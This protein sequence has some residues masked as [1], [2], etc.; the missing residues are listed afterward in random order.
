MF[1]EIL[2]ASQQHSINRSD[3]KLKKKISFFGC[4]RLVI[5]LSNSALLIWLDG[6]PVCLRYLPVYL[7]PH[8]P[9]PGSSTRLGRPT[10]IVSLS[11]SR[12]T[13]LT[14][15][16]TLDFRCVYVTLSHPDLKNPCG[17]EP[18]YCSA[19][20][21]TVLHCLLIQIGGL[22]TDRNIFPMVSV[23][24]NVPIWQNDHA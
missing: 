21:S 24:H 10:A 8:C 7:G 3:K 5:S 17:L 23:C 15:L 22:E 19:T 11:F 13:W 16:S 1:L 20:S 4:R 2:F 14:K 12:P 9:R 18:V 6:F